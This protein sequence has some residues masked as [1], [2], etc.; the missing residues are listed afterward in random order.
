[1]TVTFPHLGPLY[2]GASK[3]LSY[4][5][6]PH[7]Q[8]LP[9]GQQALTKGILMSPEEICLPFKFM[10]GNL[11][12]AYDMG[13]DTAIMISTNG[14]CRLGEYG[15]LMKLVLEDN[16]Y[17]YKWMLIG[18]GTGTGVKDVFSILRSLSTRECLRRNDI[19]KG[20]VM[21]LKLIMRNDKFRRSLQERAGYLRRPFDAVNLWKKTEKA[22]SKAETFDECFKVLKKARVDLENL[23]PDKD[24]D[25]VKVLVLGEIYTSI[26]PEANGNLEEKL[27]SLGCSVKRHIDISWWIKYSL[28]SAVVPERIRRK[29]KTGETIKNNIGGYG[30]ETVDYMLKDRW[31]DGVIKIMPSGCMPEIVT[32]AFCQSIERNEDKKMLHLIYDEMSGQAGYETRIEAFVD[33]LER[34]KRVLA[35]NRHRFHKHGPGAFRG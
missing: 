11:A 4:L 27:M 2:I 14:P 5:D 10:V 15:E 20:F 35:G 25:P 18:S 6:I 22:L 28:F 32:K 16:G 1:M 9:N 34:R 29:V 8:P 3:L 26:E 23:E 24:A 33:M 12:E 19:I 13:A 30:R 21:A 17:D 7:I 31:G